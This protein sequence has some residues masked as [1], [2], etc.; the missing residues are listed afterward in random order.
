MIIAIANNRKSETISCIQ[1]N[2]THYLPN[3]HIKLIEKIAKNITNDDVACS[4]DDQTSISQMST[5]TVIS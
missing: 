4:I 2:T 1:H 5:Q 3:I